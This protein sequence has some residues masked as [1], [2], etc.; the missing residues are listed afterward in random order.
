[1]PSITRLQYCNCDDIVQIVP[2][3]GN[4]IYKYFKNLFNSI[5]PLLKQHIEISDQKEKLV[6]RIEALSKIIK[7]NPTKL[8]GKI[9]AL[10][11]ELLFLSCQNIV[12][13][14]GCSLRECIDTLSYGNFNKPICGTLRQYL[15]WTKH[16]KRMLGSDFDV[17][18]ADK[19][20]PQGIIAISNAK[21]EISIIEQELCEL[22]NNI[23]HILSKIDQ[24]IEYSRMDKN[25]GIPTDFN[26]E[27]LETLIKNVFSLITKRRS[28]N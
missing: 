19:D 21:D 14:K 27:T 20:I 11:K 18:I 7:Q 15:H 22:N 13:N 17:S 23:Q 25:T 26:K 9:L 28:S 8:E 3:S 16:Y 10:R 4:N 12:D 5:D 1:M 24:K 2:I 6:R